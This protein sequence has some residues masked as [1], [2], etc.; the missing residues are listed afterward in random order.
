MLDFIKPVHLLERRQMKNVVIYVARNVLGRWIEERV[1]TG[2]AG[3]L[4]KLNSEIECGA[5]RILH[6]TWV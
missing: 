5:V 6:I 2:K 4:T 1:D 3:R